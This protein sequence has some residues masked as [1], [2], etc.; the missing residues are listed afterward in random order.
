LPCEGTRSGSRADQPV[1]GADQQAS[2]TDPKPGREVP[3][4]E[5][6]SHHAALV[7]MGPSTVDDAVF[8]KLVEQ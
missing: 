2:D 3:A 1:A 8:G 6:A 7:G 5:V 4:A